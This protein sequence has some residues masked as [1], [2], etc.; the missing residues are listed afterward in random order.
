MGIKTLFFGAMNSISEILGTILF[1]VLITV[2]GLL[3][4]WAKLWQGK[5]WDNYFKPSA[6]RVPFMA[7]IALLV[8]LK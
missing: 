7:R 6:S 1:F 5:Y 3:V 2:M 8:I 4:G